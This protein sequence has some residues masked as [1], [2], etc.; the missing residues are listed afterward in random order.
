MSL[1]LTCYGGAESVTG[2]NFLIEGTKG[3]I[4]VD[5]GLE[6]GIDFNEKEMHEPFAY[7][8]PSI[9]ALVI[10]HA[11][12]DHIGRAPKLVAEGFRGKVYMTPATRDL[13][14]IMLRDSVDILAQTARKHGLPLLYTDQDINTFMLL[15]ETLE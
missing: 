7:D 9:D 8:V 2:S 15:I 1:R 13:T 11:H 3:K 5:C 6:Q 12:L 4:L 14:E 10:T